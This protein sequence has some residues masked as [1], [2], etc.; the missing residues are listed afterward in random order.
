M[1]SGRRGFNDNR[2]R[3]IPDAEGDIAFEEVAAAADEVPFDAR[4]PAAEDGYSNSSRF[5]SE[6]IFGSVLPGSPHNGDASGRSALTPCNRIDSE[7]ASRKSSSAAASSSGRSPSRKSFSKLFTL[8]LF[9]KVSVVRL[10]F[11]LF[12]A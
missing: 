3:D 1:E 4:C 9:A 11:A 7:P 5:R 10:L 6:L 12:L 8:L 2:L